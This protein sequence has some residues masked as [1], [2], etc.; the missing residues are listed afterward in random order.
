MYGRIDGIWTSEKYSVEIQGN[1]GILTKLS[2]NQ[3]FNG[4]IPQLGDIVVKNLIKSDNNKYI[5]LRMFLQPDINEFAWD[6]ANFA[7]QQEKESERLFM[8]SI[9]EGKDTIIFVKN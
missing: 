9:T 3:Q 6:V 4:D 1:S 7:I 5:G 2:Y 8:V